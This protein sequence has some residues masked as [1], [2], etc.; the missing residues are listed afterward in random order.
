[1]SNN[2]IKVKFSKNSK[3]NED[4]FVTYI[5]CKKG[6]GSN[7]RLSI[8]CILLQDKSLG[9]VKGKYC[10][11]QLLDIYLIGITSRGQNDKNK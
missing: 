4:I 5:N 11:N 1:M 6:S 9:K 7:E 3:Y 10:L 2:L 8:D